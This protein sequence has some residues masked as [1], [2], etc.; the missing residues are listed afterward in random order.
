MAT[1][2]NNDPPPGTP[3]LPQLHS[4]LTS[5]QTATHIL[6]GLTHRNKN[7]HRGTKWWP[8]FNMLRR[9]LQ[10]LILDLEAAIQRAEVM[11]VVP[12][13]GKKQQQRKAA[14]T[15]KA[16]K[17]LELDRVM[18]RVAWVRAVLGPRA[19]ESFTQLTADR[20]F[21][22]LGLVL[23]G[24]LA[25]V[26]AA[27]APFV[28]AEP[29]SEPESKYRQLERDR[30]GPAGAS[31]QQVEA[32]GA[33]GPKT[34]AADTGDLDLGVAVS[35]DELDGGDFVQQP[36]VE[37]IPTPVP[38][39]LSPTTKKGCPDDPDETKIKKRKKSTSDSNGRPSAEV[40][41]AFPEQ[42]EPIK[43]PKKLQAGEPKRRSTEIETFV[44][45]SKN[46][47]SK[48][49]KSKPHAVSS[50]TG[51]KEPKTMTA[52]DKSKEVKKPKKK[53]KKGGDEFDDL[54]S[55]LL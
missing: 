47:A 39:V 48:S 11:M 12:S 37:P 34:V 33:Y 23:I 2:K 15:L 22:Q 19:Y 50:R 25:Q 55:S 8:A 13:A 49:K 35:R 36:S 52:L 53:K 31:V 21:A 29:D 10:K 5:L 51:D 41:E 27:V 24:V 14:T 32:G 30:S 7:Q 45:G 16:A 40:P 44:E 17:Q 26:E 4:T 1:L 6:A 28:P 38:R 3:S 9:S 46:D 18:E 54:F 42:S 43:R 20:Q